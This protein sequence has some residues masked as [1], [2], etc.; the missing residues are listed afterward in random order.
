MKKFKVTTIMK[1]GSVTYDTYKTSHV[2]VALDKH[3]KEK[4]EEKDESF[5][6]AFRTSNPDIVAISKN[7]KYICTCVAE[8][9]ENNKEE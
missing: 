4:W 3:F 7:K 8:E 9:I 1:D 2:M 6:Q 5:E